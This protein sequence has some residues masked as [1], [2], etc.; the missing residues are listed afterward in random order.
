M[1]KNA[2]SRSLKDSFNT[3]PDVSDVL[4]DWFQH[5]TFQLVT[6]TQQDYETVEVLTTIHTEGVRQPMSAQQLDLKPEGQRA[7][8]WETIHCLPDVKL[9]VD[10]IIIFDGVKYRV[11]QKWNWAEYG[12]LEYEICQAFTNSSEES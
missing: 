8:K 11:M 9:K 6:K 3:L 5:L 1:I 2:A 12:Y 10:D 7:W 4:P